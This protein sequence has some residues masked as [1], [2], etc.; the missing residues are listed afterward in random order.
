M[1]NFSALSSIRTTCLS[2]WK[3]LFL[4]G[5][6]LPITYVKLLTFYGFILGFLS[7]APLF[8]GYEINVLASGSIL[9][10]YSSAFY[11]AHFTQRIV[12][13]HRI[14][15]VSTSIYSFVL[16]LGAGQHFDS[17]LTAVLALVIMIA[18]SSPESNYKYNLA[19]F[20]LITSA[21]LWATFD[22]DNI[23]T[24]YFNTNEEKLQSVRVIVWFGSVLGLAPFLFS[25]ARSGKQALTVSNFERD[26]KAQALSLFSHDMSKT[27]S[28]LNDELMRALNLH[29]AMNIDGP[30]SPLGQ[31]AMR[32][33]ERSLE[34]ITAIYLQREAAQAINDRVL[35]QPN[36]GLQTV[37]ISELLAS[38]KTF[39]EHRARARK[40]PLVFDIEKE[41][42]VKTIPNLLEYSCVF[43]LLDNAF[44]FSPSG[45]FVKCTVRGSQT[46]VIISIFDQG[47]GIRKE[48]REKIFLPNFSDRSQAFDTTGTGV[49]L[50]LIE[51]NL[52][53]IGG[54]ISFETRHSSEIEDA[55]IETS[56][57]RFTIL[58][59]RAE[60]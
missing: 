10:V 34:F 41:L 16:I 9:L 54:S 44:A 32:S 58:I 5:A 37:N 60:T 1:G 29:G 48:I 42:Y 6:D 14:F 17:I 27:I 38:R 45:K 55:S 20:A 33:I 53:V 40:I 43:N 11:L 18:L 2:Y 8:I 56:F 4:E 59:P 15:L 28:D 52:K 22:S 31:D 50:G 24:R 12:F 19:M 51:N 46:H 35:H 36:L 21:I 47:C 25:Y 23:L 39:Y 13:A 7:V 3:L 57:T 26:K 49:G 30:I